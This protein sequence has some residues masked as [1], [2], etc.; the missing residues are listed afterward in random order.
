MIQWLRLHLP[1]QGVWVQSLVGELRSHMSLGQ[2]TKTQVA[3]VVKNPP[4]NAGDVR[5]TGSNPGLGRSLGEG[6]G[7]RLQ[8]SCLENPREQGNLAGYSSWG[9]KQSDITEVT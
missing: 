6:S 1:M 2:K 7:N 9:H 5:D 8:Y 4:A 3:L